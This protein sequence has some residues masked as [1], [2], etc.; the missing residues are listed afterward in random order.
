MSSSCFAQPGEPTVRRYADGHWV[1]GRPRPYRLPVSLWGE[2]GVNI[3]GRSAQHYGRCDD[4]APDRTLY[5]WRPQ[6]CE[7]RAF[8]PPAACEA[9]RG[10]QLVFVGDSTLLQLFLS[11]VLLLRGALGRNV[12]K[13]S[14]V[15]DVTASACNDTVRLAFARSDLLLWTHSSR[16]VAAARRCDPFVSLGTFVARAE[17]SHRASPALCPVRHESRARRHV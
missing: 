3:N 12:R 16:D 17:G 13:T 7:L 9:L 6:H 2:L 1:P 8:E 11:F 10:R 15:Q 5:D 4:V 14:T